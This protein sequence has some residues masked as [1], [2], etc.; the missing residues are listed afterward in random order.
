MRS[1]V[2]LYAKSTSIAFTAVAALFL[3]VSQGCA[4]TH[5]KHCRF[6]LSLSDP[7]KDRLVCADHEPIATPDVDP[8]VR[9]CVFERSSE[10]RKANP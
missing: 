10:L 1:T 9:A 3:L 4:V 7:A 6:Q 2:I 5:L 8:V